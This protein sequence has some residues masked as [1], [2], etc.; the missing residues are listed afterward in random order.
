MITYNNKTQSARAWAKE[1][2]MSHTTLLRRQ[3][4]GMTGEEII[5]TQRG[6][7]RPCKKKLKYQLRNG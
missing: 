6:K 4:A 1:L 3:A 2:G 7:G 5:T